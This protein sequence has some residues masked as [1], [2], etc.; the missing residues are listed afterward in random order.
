[1]RW[2]AT[3][4][5]ACLYLQGA[6]VAP[7]WG[8]TST[9][10]REYEIKAAFLYHFAQFVEWPEKKEQIMLCVLGSDPFGRA[11]DNLKDK[12]VKEKTLTA[13]RLDRIR[14]ARHCHVL[15][16]SPSEQERLPQVLDTLRASNVLTVGETQTFTQSGGVIRLFKAGNK[17]RF[18][19]NLEAARRA[20]LTISSRMLKLA[21]TL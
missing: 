16:I 12:T 19:V 1:M 8:Q 14:E 4:L 10:T 5:L 6:V 2:A 21:D 3:V 20:K 15:F 13:R 18:E 9:P 7:A 11:L 17:I